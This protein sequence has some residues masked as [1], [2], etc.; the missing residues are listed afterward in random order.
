MNVNKPTIFY[1]IEVADGAKFAAEFVKFKGYKEQII[2]ALRNA[3]EGDAFDEDHAWSTLWTAAYWYF[4][5]TKTKQLALRPSRRA[6]RLRELENALRKTRRLVHN[7]MYDDVGF[8][9]LRARCAEANISPREAVTS[10]DE[11]TIIPFAEALKK[12]VAEISTLEAVAKT[13][14]DNMSPSAGAPSE[15]GILTGGDLSAL[16]AF[17]QRWTGK[18]PLLKPGPFAE[19]VQLFLR[20]VGRS[21]DTKTDYVVE[22]FKYS[23]RRARKKSA[24]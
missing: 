23:K 7:A 10:K 21:S 1:K 11:I 20:A 8:D 12:L 2:A 17:Y 3:A 9:L 14:A 24:L 4:L 6:Q 16:K 13:A 19:F 18:E 15:T 5:R 22:V